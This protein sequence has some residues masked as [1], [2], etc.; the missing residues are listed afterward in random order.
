[1]ILKFTDVGK[2]CVVQKY[3]RSDFHQCCV[4]VANLKSGL[5][6]LLLLVSY[7]DFLIRKKWE[8]RRGGKKKPRKEA[9]SLIIMI[10]VLCFLDD[11]MVI[12]FCCEHQTS[13]DFM[14][15]PQSTLWSETGLGRS[16]SIWCFFSSSS[17]QREAGSLHLPCS[18]TGHL[19]VS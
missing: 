2:E 18:D 1:M 12:C 13:Q 10:A 9:W 4:C 6:A 3:I 11:F 16:R 7:K 14:H 5:S 17:K 15:L 19:C 8:K